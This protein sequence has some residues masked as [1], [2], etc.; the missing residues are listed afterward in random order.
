M[1]KSED[2]FQVYQRILNK[3]PEYLTAIRKTEEA[4]M[5]KEALG[6]GEVLKPKEVLGT[7]EVLEPE[8]STRIYLYTMV[9]A[10]IEFVNWVLDEAVQSGKKRLYFLSRDG[11]QMYLTA[12]R[13]TKLRGIEMDCRYLHVSRY[14]MRVPSYHLE[15]ENCL[16]LICVGGIDV[17]LEKILRRTALSTEEAAEVIYS[18]GWQDKYNKI[19]N[20]R[21]VQELKQILRC[22]KKLLHYIDK[23]SREAYENAM[24]YLAQEGLLSEVP[25]AL[26]DSGWVGT[27]QQSVERLIHSKKED[28]R[29]EGYYFGLY[30][31]P[32][33]VDATTYH[34]WYFTPDSGLVRKVHF[35]NS[36]FETIC[37]A[38]EGMTEGYDWEGRRY[39]PVLGP[40]GNPNGEQ[41]RRNAEALDVFL[42]YN[43]EAAIP[44]SGHN[45]ERT[46]SCRRL[47]Q[48]LFDKMMANPTE[49]EVEAYGNNLF[50]DDVVD[51]NWKQVAAELSEEQIKDQRLLHK[52]WILAGC[53]RADIH[54]SAWIEGSIVRCGGRRMKRNL[55][56][57]R[58]YKYFVYARKQI[59]VR[60]K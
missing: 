20:Y 59:R 60:K 51:R 19:L 58:F 33:D 32:K 45:G 11:Y 4:L 37:S 56:H 7:G 8:L 3:R 13:L 31:L 35:S 41:M 25:Y 10:L 34:A 38:G 23:H 48:R 50:S 52:L 16:D 39:L 57:A 36:L 26:V 28:I 14:S 22:K 46:G 44:G 9:P 42:K 24:G 1:K 12:C 15:L 53:R 54:E 17:T 27:L 43:G 6:T 5:P 40:S 47:V 55:L 21:Q 30:E 2:R 29:V 49:L 18:I